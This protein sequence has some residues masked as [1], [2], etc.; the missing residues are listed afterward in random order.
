MSRCLKKTQK[1]FNDKQTSKSSVQDANSDGHQGPTLRANV[2]STEIR[3]SVISVMS[4][5]GNVE[6]IS[7]TVTIIPDYKMDRSSP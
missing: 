5:P 6:L 4:L 3:V 2:C 7:D 1:T